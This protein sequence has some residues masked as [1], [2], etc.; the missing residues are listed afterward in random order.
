[1]DTPAD[2][3]MIP[4]IRMTA[5]C[6]KEL[7]LR[8]YLRAAAALTCLDIPIQR[9]TAYFLFPAPA[10]FF[11]GLS[12]P[13]I[14]PVNADKRYSGRRSF[15]MLPDSDCPVIL[16]KIQVVPNYSK[17]MTVGPS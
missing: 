12:S 1:M 4:G 16:T 13:A 5:T 11:P 14:R 9:N 8:A 6:R 2:G 10:P 7:S 3:D 17:S 15:F